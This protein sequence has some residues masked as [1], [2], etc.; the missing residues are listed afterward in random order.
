MKLTPLG[1]TII[2]AAAVAAQNITTSESCLIGLDEMTDEI[3]K[4]CLVGGKP[5][6]A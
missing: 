5:S 4:K 3:K 1:V 2:L 6:M